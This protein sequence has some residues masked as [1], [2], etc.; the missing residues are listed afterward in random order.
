MDIREEMAQHPAR[1]FSFNTPRGISAAS[2]RAIGDGL[3]VP[4]SSQLPYAQ[5]ELR[6]PDEVNLLGVVDLEIR[7]TLE[8]GAAR[9]SE[10]VVETLET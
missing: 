8:C 5:I 1:F 4:V 3:I 7:P 2:V 6:F 10:G 9:G